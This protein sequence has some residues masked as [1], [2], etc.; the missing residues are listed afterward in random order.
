[1]YLFDDKEEPYGILSNLANTPFYVKKNLWTT[2][3]QYIYTN[4]VTDPSMKEIMKRDVLT[5]TD[6]YSLL[7]YMEDEYWDKKFFDGLKVAL[8]VLID[9]NT[10]LQNMLKG[11]SRVRFKDEPKMENF[12]NEKR[13]ELLARTSGAFF[14]TPRVK[15]I[16][17]GVS[18]ALKAG[19][20]IDPNSTLNDLKEYDT[21]LPPYDIDDKD[22]IFSH[23][24]E[25]IPYIQ[26]KIKNETVVRNY[27]Q[28]LARFKKELFNQYLLN[29]LRIDYPGHEEEYYLNELDNLLKTMDKSFDTSVIDGIYKLF[30]DGKL[31]DKVLESIGAP[32][33]EP[34]LR[35][36]PPTKK[37]IQINPDSPLY[38]YTMGEVDINGVRYRSPLHYTYG[39][40]MNILT[41]PIVINDYAKDE[42]GHVFNWHYNEYLSKNLRILADIG[43]KSKLETY[44][45]LIHLLKTTKDHIVWG[46]TDPVLGV[47]KDGNGENA[48]GDILMFY[49]YNWEPINRP[50]SS[51]LSPMHNIFVRHWALMR[52]DDIY[53]SMN[54]MIAPSTDSLEDLYRF[55]KSNQ[56]NKFE[57]LHP[58]DRKIIGEA[59]PELSDEMLKIAWPLMFPQIY[60]ITMLTDFD[61]VNAV[62]RAQEIYL[63]KV[64]SDTDKDDVNKYLQQYFTRNLSNMK[65]NTSASFVGRILS[66]NKY[67]KVVSSDDIF[68]VAL[69]PRIFYWLDLSKAEN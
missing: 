55:P 28:K 48:V 31:A 36:V 20:K 40:L 50:V 33:D 53:N 58:E 11:S 56:D 54:T 18:K 38:P 49:R 69:N 61:L 15:R 25:L 46:D 68:K 16:I 17:Y 4:M 35:F 10:D 2:V 42:L 27:R 52:L 57:G 5:T 51:Y 21:N 29:K 67:T 6:P 26:F 62:V 14:P 13:T 8:N 3:N 60:V 12:L 7:K 24:H 30:L 65:L 66:G 59:L 44:T 23:L 22:E 63:G 1:M 32:P 37:E 19:E 47:G 45:V 9:R 34:D 41:I 64:P 39:E 43:I